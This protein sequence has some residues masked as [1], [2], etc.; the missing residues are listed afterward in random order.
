MEFP[1]K[2]GCLLPQTVSRYDTWRQQHR[3]TYEIDPSIQSAP[4]QPDRD[5]MPQATA[6]AAPLVTT[7]NLFLRVGVTSGD[8]S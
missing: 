7:M 1:Y 4:S 8:V 2:E 5:P 6:K 3:G